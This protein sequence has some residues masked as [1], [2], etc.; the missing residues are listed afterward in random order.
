MQGFEVGDLNLVINELYKNELDA[1]DFILKPKETQKMDVIA[2]LQKYHQVASM[3]T[4]TGEE[5]MNRATD[6]VSSCD[7]TI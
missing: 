2:I 3:G 6:G 1:R 4:S 7:D 5:S